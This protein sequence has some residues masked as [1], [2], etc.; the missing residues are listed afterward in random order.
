VKN[1]LQRISLLLVALL[2]GQQMK[3][4]DWFPFRETNK[5]KYAFSIGGGAVLFGSGYNNA[6]VDFN[7]TI[8]GAHLNIMGLGAIHSK[9]TSVEKQ[10]DKTCFAVH[11]GYQIP[12]T[13]SLRVIPLVG[14]ALLDLGYTDGSRWYSDSN[15]IHNKF[16]T[17][18]EAG[19][20]DY[21]GSVV[22]NHKMLL[23]SAAYTTHTAYASIGV[24]F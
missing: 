18:G 1:F 15:G 17:T 14:Y 20:F 24:E 23:V 8:W 12:I 7:T 16:V 19:E 22:F 5:A 21:G 4:V 6:A 3:A 13:K 10:K 2:V 11:V 9:D